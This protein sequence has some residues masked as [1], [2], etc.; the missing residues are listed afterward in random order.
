MAYIFAIHLLL[1]SIPSCLH[2][3]ITL[4]HHDSVGNKT[5]REKMKQLP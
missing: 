3:G 2:D 4:H 1:P 5:N